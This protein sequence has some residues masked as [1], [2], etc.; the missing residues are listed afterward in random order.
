MRQEQYSTVAGG[1]NETAGG[2]PLA[3]ND[4]PV[5]P[6]SVTFIDRWLTRRLLQLIGNPPLAFRLWNDEEIIPAGQKAT[7]VLSIHSRRAL[8]KLFSD[9]EFNFGALYSSSD[10]DVEGDLPRFLEVVYNTTHYR[11]QTFGDHF[12]EALQNYRSRNLSLQRTRE[13]IQHHYDIGNDFYRQW[14][15]SAAMQY[16]CAYFPDP[17]M[18]LD[19]AQIA[20]LH[21]VCRKLELQPGQSVVEAGCGWG[22]LALFMAEHYGVRVRAYNISHEQI[23]YARQQ[24]AARGLAEQVDFIEDDYRNIEGTYDRFVSVGMLEHIGIKNYPGLGRLIDRV[25]K[26]EGVGLIHSIGRNRPCRL[27]SW[28]ETRIFPGACPPSLGQ[29]MEIF[30]PQRF[31]ILDVENLRLHY[32]LTLK[33]WLQRFETHSEDFRKQFDDAFIRAWRLYLAGSIAAF[34]GGTMQLF[35]VVFS[36]PRN[37]RLPMSRAHLYPPQAGN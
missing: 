8:Y 27:N 12:I 25:L 26:A 30:E 16:T 5:V 10:I 28:I 11:A 32:A 19:A 22:G 17:Q 18:S 29:M 35:Q 13:N 4:K 31:S 9:P 24:A 2:Q 36:R 37:N 34:N 6:S 23:V 21:H 1:K 33:H 3:A 7:S 15:D 20:K 14:L